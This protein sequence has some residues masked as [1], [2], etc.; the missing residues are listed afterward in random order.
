MHSLKAKQDQLKETCRHLEEQ[1]KVS[2]DDSKVVKAEL[3]EQK[4]EWK[5]AIKRIKALT[6]ERSMTAIKHQQEMQVLHDELQNQPMYLPRAA[7]TLDRQPA[8][9]EVLYYFPWEVED[10]HM[11][12]TACYHIA[13]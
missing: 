12:E 6:A 3:Q 11:L 5:K 9:S 1:W 8:R 2:S 4:A 10:C 7:V 13:E